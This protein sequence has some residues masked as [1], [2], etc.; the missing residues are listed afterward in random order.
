M[1]VLVTACF[2]HWATRFPTHT[3]D[4]AATCRQMVDRQ[5]TN[6]DIDGTFHFSG[7]E[8]FTK[9]EMALIMAR[10]TGVDALLTPSRRPFE[11]AIAEALTP[12]FG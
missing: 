12:H 10:A 5:A 8:A 7:A 6:G 3:Q 9:Y 2:D 4:V 11:H 1:R